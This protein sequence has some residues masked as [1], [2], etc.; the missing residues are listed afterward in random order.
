MAGIYHSSSSVN[1][2][3]QPASQPASNRLILGWRQNTDLIFQIS[4]PSQIIVVRN[5]RY[6]FQLANSWPL[7]G[8]TC[9]AI[10]LRQRLHASCYICICTYDRVR[11]RMLLNVL[12]KI[13]LPCTNLLYAVCTS[14]TIYWPS[15]W[16]VFQVNKHC[17]SFVFPQP[18][19]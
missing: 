1:N 2:N 3:R 14:C 15:I 8:L 10:H 13:V 11:S 12:Y 9:P 19:V 16:L 18:I 5:T 4:R 17:N 6:R 7:F